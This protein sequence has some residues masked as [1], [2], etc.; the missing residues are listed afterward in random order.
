MVDFCSNCS[1]DDESAMRMIHFSRRKSLWTRNR[2]MKPWP[3]ITTHVVLGLWL[4][5]VLGF[6]PPPAPT[7]SSIAVAYQPPLDRST[8]AEWRGKRERKWR[9]KVKIKGFW[10]R[11]I[12]LIGGIEGGKMVEPKRETESRMCVR[13]LAPPCTPPPRQPQPDHNNSRIA[14]SLYLSL[15]LFCV[16][17]KWFCE[18]KCD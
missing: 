1:L 12:D 5:L 14:R 10:K 2:P 3:P 4:G 7:W 17:I 13:T 6:P 18:A 15:D 9:G 11:G 8:A 16:L